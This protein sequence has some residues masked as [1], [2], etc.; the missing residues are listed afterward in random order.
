[1][2]WL[3]YLFEIH[4]CTSNG[5][6]V[7]HISPIACTRKSRSSPHTAMMTKSL[8]RKTTILLWKKN[9]YI[10]L[11]FNYSYHLPK[12]CNV[13]NPLFQKISR[14]WPFKGSII[15]RGQNYDELIN[16]QLEMTCELE[17]IHVWTGASLTHEVHEFVEC[18]IPIRLKH[19]LA[20]QPNTSTSSW[21]FPTLNI[22]FIDLVRQKKLFCVV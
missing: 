4:T 20:I 21:P 13:I 17:L 19:G 8:R 10:A 14:F 18:F 9:V 16:G 22:K 1:M 5:I 6:T 15:Q 2:A 7:E 11:W 3:N 12:M